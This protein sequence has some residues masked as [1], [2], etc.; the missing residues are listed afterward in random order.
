MSAAELRPGLSAEQAWQLMELAEKAVMAQS[1]QDLAERV[2]PSV[3]EMTQSRLAFLY[4][5]DAQLPAP[6]F[7]QNGGQP[8]AAAQIEKLCAEHFDP[9]AAQ[10]GPVSISA[11]ATW[12]TDTQP[13]LVLYSL[14][15]HETCVGL[16]GLAQPV[17][18]TPALPGLLERLDGLLAHTIDRL[19]ERARAERQL[20][21]L[22]TYLTVSS[23]L[24]QSQSLHEL[25]EAALY[26]C[27]EAVS[28]ETAS[29]LLLDDEKKNF[30][31]YHVEGP[32]KPILM[33]ATFPADKGLAGS[34]LQVR[35]SEIVNDAQNDPRFYRQIDSASSFQTRNMIVIPLVAGKEQV[36][37]LEV[38]NKADEGAFTD[39]E[40]LLLLSLAEEIAFAIR[41]ATLFEYVANTYCKQRQGRPSCR[42]CERPLGSWTP[43]VRY[44]EAS[45][46]FFIDRT[47]L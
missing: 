12:Q 27:M 40:R 31:F 33:G 24:A 8:E 46:I 6:R 29:V 16:I 37:V 26:C 35:Q 36:G 28:A 15:S 21:F 14:R 30:R 34:V 38:L 45:G 42:G 41:N 13:G 2:L 7:F 5:A 10:A 4:I 1:L 39:E 18:V 47:R 9:V 44:R 19:V 22:N 3:A 43:C 20:A 11:P 32:A 25:L 23:M 17:G